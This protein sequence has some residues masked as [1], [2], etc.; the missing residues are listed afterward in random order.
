MNRGSI[1][2][3]KKLIWQQK[4]IY[5]CFLNK[6]WLTKTVTPVYDVVWAHWVKYRVYDHPRVTVI[7][8][9][10]FLFSTLKVIFALYACVRLLELEDFMRQLG[11]R[12]NSSQ[13]PDSWAFDGLPVSECQ[14]VYGS[15]WALLWW[16]I[17]Q[18]AASVL[19]FILPVFCFR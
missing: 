4:G 18:L 19:L 8:C 7:K 2:A 11:S 16:T 3:I 6:C 12:Y 14:Y 1:V 15:N 13:G 5:E 17:M 10:L 9:T